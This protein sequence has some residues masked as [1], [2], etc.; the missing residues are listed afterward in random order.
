MFLCNICCARIG[1]VL[2]GNAA[3]PH[4]GRMIDTVSPRLFTIS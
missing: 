2:P 4:F 1:A 3:L